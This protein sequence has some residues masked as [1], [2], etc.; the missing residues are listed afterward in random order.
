M[1]LVTFRHD[2]MLHNWAK[3]TI[4]QY[5]E[6]E[7]YTFEYEHIT[8]PAQKYNTI[9]NLNNPHYGSDYFARVQKK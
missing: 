7:N 6:N 3:F 1:L 5:R 8:I 4:M 9:P 2:L